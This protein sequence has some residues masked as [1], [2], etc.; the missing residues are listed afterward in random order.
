[1]KKIK[2]IIMAIPLFIIGISTKVLAIADSQMSTMYGVPKD[3]VLYG[4]PR[5]YYLDPN[6]IPG[7]DSG[8]ASS[9]FNAWGIISKFCIPFILLIGII[10]YFKKS[11]SSMK[12]KVIISIL[13]I[14]IVFL[15]CFGINYLLNMAK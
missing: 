5:N 12:K 13:T 7:I 14:L 10:I 8:N 11:K 9:V 3:Q 2:K 6:Q 4:P 15:I 1:M